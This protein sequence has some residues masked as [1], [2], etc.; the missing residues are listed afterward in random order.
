MNSLSLKVAQRYVG[1]DDGDFYTGS[2]EG[3]CGEN[4][5]YNPYTGKCDPMETQGTKIPYDLSI[6]G[7]SGK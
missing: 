4:E 7:L 5:V 1:Q 2:I 3:I 6:F